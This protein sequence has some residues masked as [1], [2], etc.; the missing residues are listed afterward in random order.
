[1]IGYLSF[2]VLIPLAAVVWKSTGSGLEGFWNAV[3]SPAAV[4]SLKLTLGASIV[5]AGSIPGE[6]RTVSLAM[7]GFLETGRDGDA[8]RL[9]AVSLVIALAAVWLSNRLVREGA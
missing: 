5:V 7:Y 4:A 6:T 2:I 1:M 9:V 8:M 3:T